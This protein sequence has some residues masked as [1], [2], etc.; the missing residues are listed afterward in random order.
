MT[1]ALGGVSVLV[2]RPEAQGRALCEAI[3][4]QGGTAVPAPMIEIER[5][6]IDAAMGRTLNHIAQF[7]RVIFV[8]RNA[9]EFGLLALDEGGMTLTEQSLYA[10]GAGTASALSQHGH[11]DVSLPASDYSSTGLLAL[12]TLQAKAVDGTRVLIF[13]GQG[14][15]EELANTLI[16]RG[17]SV[18]YCEVYARRPASATI[19][20]ALIQC[21]LNEVQFAIVTSREILKHL[22]R[23]LSSEGLHQLFDMTLI[24]VG[25]SS[26]K[27][28]PKL[29]FTK[30]PLIVD[31]PTDNA[32]IDALI[33]GTMDKL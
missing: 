5:L 30:P 18:S 6:P 14:G 8:S 1:A 12:E 33:A 17:A 11:E 3:R 13:R 31:N 10:I 32:L 21:G 28:V 19:S 23:K 2:T 29:G 9:V 26:A 7:E 24:V 15:R 25:A 20:A 4:A 27:A 22:A 16:E